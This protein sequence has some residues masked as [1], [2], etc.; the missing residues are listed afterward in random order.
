[1]RIE[2]AV[3]VLGAV[4]VAVENDI[5]L[6]SGVD[7]AV[8]V[9]GTKGKQ[10]IETGWIALSHVES[11]DAT[12]GPAHDGGMVDGKVVEYSDDIV[13]HSGVGD[14]LIGSL[15]RAAVSARVDGQHRMFA[16]VFAHLKTPVVRVGKAAVKESDWDRIVVF[17]LGI[18]R[19]VPVPDGRAIG[20][21]EVGRLA[22]AGEVWSGGKSEVGLGCRLIRER[23]LGSEHGRKIEN[24]ES[25]VAN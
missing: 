2:T 9:A 16:H 7:V 22:A 6:D 24:E 25:E 1:M 11:N 19:E 13:S 14:G 12:V 18:G 17:V 8:R 4:E 20:P 10:A 3:L 15:N 5:V 21:L 23:L